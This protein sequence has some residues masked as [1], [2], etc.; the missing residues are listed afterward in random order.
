MDAHHSAIY[1]LLA[2]LSIGLAGATCERKME[3]GSTGDAGTA[4]SPESAD[5]V[6]DT[7]GP[8]E[9]IDAGSSDTLQMADA[10]SDTE[11]TR[12]DVPD[13]DGGD[14]D[15]DDNAADPSSKRYAQLSVGG[16]HACALTKKD[17]KSID[18]WGLGDEQGEEASGNDFNQAVPPSGQFTEVAAGHHHTCAVR[19][20]G[21]LTCWGMGSDP[22]T[23]ENVTLDYDQAV[24]PEGNDFVDVTTGVFHSC[25]M[26]Q[27]GAV[28]CWGKSTRNDPPFNRT[29]VPDRNFEGLW[30][31]QHHNCGQLPDGSLD[32]WGGW[33]FMQWP[34][35]TDGGYVDVAAGWTFTCG[36][37]KDGEIDCW[38]H[39]E[40]PND[41]FGSVDSL[42]GDTYTKQLDYDQAIPP[43]G[44]YT[45][46]AAGIS[47]HAC[48][49]D[50]SG[51]V[52][53][54][55]RGTVENMAGSGDWGQSD[56]PSAGFQ[57]LSLG[58]NF[59]CGLRTDDRVQCWGQNNYGQ[60]IPQDKE[61]RGEITLTQ[62]PANARWTAGADFK[63]VSEDEPSE[64]RMEGS[65]NG[66]RV[67]ICDDNRQSQP[68]F[69]GAGEIRITGGK[70]N[71]TMNERADEIGYHAEGSG[72]IYDGDQA[73]T[74]EAAGNEVPEFSAGLRPA[75]GATMESPDLPGSG[76]SNMS[77]DTSDDLPIEWNAETVNG[78]VDVEF[79][80]T[81]DGSVSRVS[82]N[83]A[84]EAEQKTIPAKLLE[85]LY[86]GAGRYRFEHRS[87]ESF[88]VENYSILIEAKTILDDADP[89]TDDGVGNAMFE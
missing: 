47:Q 36:L 73:L 24:P 42:E 25:A 63:V 2:M 38:G 18:C 27:G 9:A 20:E 60:L 66:C 48:A 88:R 52:S 1:G 72:P 19:Q 26:R 15:R 71:I 58:K 53:C 56:P 50:D 78:M 44:S 79:L 13:P 86:T 67:T 69:K 11:P 89:A 75:F 83:W 4:E 87:A 8:D 76:S 34:S 3:V 65:E 21:S 31:G 70:Q 30:T 39:G 43:E 35:S 54:W 62:T 81:Q 29:E 17:D 14:G 57:Q 84:V 45:E 64:C 6:V 12:N 32:C 51:S 74:F 59:S 41:A 85:K 7:G 33:D 10:G 77:V 80:T 46:I 61:W 16:N 82:C 22:D 55:G 23:E 40:E 68:E 49:I 28:E 37:R 5:V